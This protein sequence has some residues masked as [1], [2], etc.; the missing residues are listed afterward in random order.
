MPGLGD[1]EGIGAL[2]NAGYGE[3]AG[4]AGNS[5]FARYGYGSTGQHRSSGTTG[6]DSA[7]KHRERVRD[8]C[9]IHHT[10][11]Q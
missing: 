5:R 4:G 8:W 1:S 11:R 7:G 9:Q 6:K 2:W 10:N 3:G